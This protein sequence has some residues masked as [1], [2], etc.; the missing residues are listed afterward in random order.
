MLVQRTVKAEFF[1]LTN[2]K[3]KAL[4]ALWKEWNK[5]LKIEREYR[6]LREETRLPSYYCRALGW[7]ASDGRETPILIDKDAFKIVDTDNVHARFFVSIPV[8]DGR[9]WCPLRMWWKHREL[10]SQKQ[11]EFADSQIVKR[12]GK[13]YLHLIVKKQITVMPEYSSVLSVDLGERFLATSVVLQGT[14][15]TAPKFYGKKAR[16]IRRH[17]AWLRK[18]L[19]ERKLL[20][21]IRRI[22]HTEQRKINDLCHKI[23]RQI[24]EQAEKHNAV[25]VVGDLEGIRERTRSKGKRLRRIVD[26]M[27]YYKLTEYIRYKALWKGI[28]V[29]LANED[30]TSQTCHKC[31][32]IGKRLSQ[33]LFKCSCGLEYNADLNGAI[34]IGKRFLDHVLRDGAL[35]FRFLREPLLS[36]Q[37]KQLDRTWCTVTVHF[38]L[39]QG[40]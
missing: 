33:G 27:P 13:F 10:I 37:V 11:V 22:G 4:E 39:P 30:Y 40:L 12:K 20:K 29:I 8:L 6:T 9:V 7:K 21:V 38:L 24:V 26:H 23:A 18:R 17:Y 25:I 35:G 32:S 14:S 31:H 5:S 1:D 28:A 3:K 15:M 36:S 34:N 16:G 19:G 2:V